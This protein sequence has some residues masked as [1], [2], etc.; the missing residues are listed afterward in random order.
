MKRRP[1]GGSRL[2][3]SARR[4]TTWTS[5]FICST[6]K[7]RVNYLNCPSRESHDWDSQLGYPAGL[8]TSTRWRRGWRH[9]IVQEVK[10]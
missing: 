1:Q 3:T 10:S 7:T 4:M 9:A 5:G 8:L 6:A 2:T